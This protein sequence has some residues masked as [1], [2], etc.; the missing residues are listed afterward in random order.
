MDRNFATTLIGS[1][2]YRSAGEALDKVTEGRITYPAWPQLPALGYNESMYAQTGCRLPGIR[3]DD[4]DKKITVDLKRYDPGDI[5]EAILSEDTDY[6]EHPKKYHS[7]LYEFLGRDL[8]GFKAVKGQVTGPISEGLQITDAEGRSVIYDDAYSEIIRRAVNLTAKR[9]WKD[10]A[11]HN[12]NVIIFF[13]EPS[14]TM[15]G[16]PFASISNDDAVD[17]INESMDGLKCDKA[18]HCCGNTD[19]PLIFR[20]D[21]DILSFDAYAYSHTI[22]MFPDEVS[23]FLEKGGTLSWGMIPSTD[24]LAESETAE[25]LVRMFRDNISALV[26]KGVDEDLIV[27]RSMV[28]PQCGLGAMEAKNADRMIAMLYD[29][30][31]AMK[32]HYGAE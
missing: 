23:K 2:P 10:L 28:T 18:I 15:L 31:N 27:R 29:V 20:T 25:H 32:K 26:K 7:G 17:W 3:I 4:L 8:S 12:K 1:L 24:D 5:Y 21:M 22:A 30:S 19:W 16:T 6:F 14:L 13:D 11:E 9:Q